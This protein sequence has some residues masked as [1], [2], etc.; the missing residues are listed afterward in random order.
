MF[1]HMQTLIIPLRLWAYPTSPRV[2]SCSYVCLCVSLCVVGTL[3]EIYSFNTFWNAQHSVVWVGQWQQ[4]ELLKI[5]KSREVRG[6]LREVSLNCCQSLIFIEHTFRKTMYSTSEGFLTNRMLQGMC[7]Q[8]GR[9]ITMT[10]N[11]IKPHA[12]SNR[13]AKHIMLQR[14]QCSA[15]SVALPL[16][17]SG[18]SRLVPHG[19]PFYGSNI[20]QASQT[21]AM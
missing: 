12:P 18:L 5:G 9:A 4:K 16:S 17:S 20:H 21:T 10:S 15:C 7:R 2:S 8:S 3:H 6:R 14:E 13:Q 11:K 19:S 1:G